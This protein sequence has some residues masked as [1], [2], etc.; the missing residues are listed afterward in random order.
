MLSLLHYLSK[1]HSF[2]NNS[3]FN[4]LQEAFNEDQGVLL[5]SAVNVD[6]GSIAAGTTVDS[7]IIFL[8]AR[9]SATDIDR[10]WTFSG[11]ILGVQSDIDGGLM[12]ASDSIFTSNTYFTDVTGGSGFSYQ[13]LESNDG[14]MIIGTLLNQLTLTMKV[15]EPGDWI[16][17]ITASAVPVPAAIWL[18][19]PALLGFVGMR[20][21]SK[22]A[23]K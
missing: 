13:G 23:V 4:L 22:L 14:Y 15:S 8:N 2:N 18:F 3:P 20:R 21:K 16:R 5:G 6:D 17:V 9:G 7:H 10:E 12:A 11:K 1:N 19:G